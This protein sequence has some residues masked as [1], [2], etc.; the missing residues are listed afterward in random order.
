M[1]ESHLFLDC[2]LTVSMPVGSGINKV[3]GT[4]GEELRLLTALSIL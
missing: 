2:I 3:S 1:A 4:L